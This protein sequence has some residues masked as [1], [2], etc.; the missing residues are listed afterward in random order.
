MSTVHPS[1][2][3]GFSQ[4]AETY[5]QGRPDYP[6]DVDVWL[7]EKIGLGPGVS[8]VDLGAGTGKFTGRLIGTGADVLAVDPVS[9][10]LERLV[11]A[12]PGVEARV[13]SAQAIPLDDASVD[14]VVCAQSFHWF[15]TSEALAEIRRVLKPG[16]RLG[17]VWNVR[18]H[19]VPWVAR[20]TAM[21]DVYNVD[22]QAPRYH[23]GQWRQPFPAEGFGPLESARFAHGGHMGAPGDVIVKRG[24]SVSFI[25]ALPEDVRARVAEEIR[26]LISETPELAGRDRV[27]FP[28]VT[29]AYSCVK[30]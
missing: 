13:G 16:G 8:A 10:M 28:Y 6:P 30:T 26:G 3:R 14:A 29:E 23:L 12:H 15:A 17:L 5:S 27:S 19:S 21:L 22:A 9:E 7:S 18:D 1:A 25:A 20:F 24:L 11:Q 4:G 2:V